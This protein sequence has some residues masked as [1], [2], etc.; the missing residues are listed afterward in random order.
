MDWDLGSGIGRPSSNCRTSSEELTEGLLSE[1][2]KRSASVS[3][4]NNNININTDE[5]LRVDDGYWLMVGGWLMA[6]CRAWSSLFP[7]VSTCIP[8]RLRI[9]KNGS[10]HAQKRSEIRTV[11]VWPSF[12]PKVRIRFFSNYRGPRC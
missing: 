11:S 5:D 12:I 6:A 9:P 10:T 7:D 3:V 2:R 1:P 4:I 8:T